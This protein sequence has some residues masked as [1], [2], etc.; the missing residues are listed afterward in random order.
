MG[1]VSGISEEVRKSIYEKG[2][3]LR[4]H[5]LIR[6]INADLTANIIIKFAGASSYFPLMY[7]TLNKFT[8]PDRDLLNRYVV[9]WTNSSDYGPHIGSLSLLCWYVWIC[10][11][12]GLKHL[13]KLINV[14]GRGV[15][16]YDPEAT[17]ANL[18]FY[19][20]RR[21]TSL[22]GGLRSFLSPMYINSF[23]SGGYPTNEEIDC[24][25]LAE[26]RRLICPDVSKRMKWDYRSIVHPIRAGRWDIAHKYIDAGYI[27]GT[28]RGVLTSLTENE[29]RELLSRYDLWK[30][31]LYIRIYDYDPKHIIPSLLRGGILHR[32]FANTHRGIDIVTKL[33]IPLQEVPMNV[34]ED[35]FTLT[36][37]RTAKYR[38][39]TLSSTPLLV[40]NIDAWFFRDLT[41]QEGKARPVSCCALPS[42]THHL[43]HINYVDEILRVLRGGNEGYMEKVYKMMS[44]LINGGRVNAYILESDVI[45]SSY[46]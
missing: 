46:R 21:D 25:V 1:N 15:T 22:W 33:P 10:K 26:E 41:R 16:P 27:A 30:T 36:L 9:S 39:K 20:E 28:C 5:P 31:L 13:V 2:R 40:S 18:D 19:F 42:S 29:L 17:L 4:S 44:N 45:P 43:Y 8:T 14:H 6:I 24:M 37:L 23:E 38:R 35:L 7:L 32:E 11:K 34:I 12:V 3:K